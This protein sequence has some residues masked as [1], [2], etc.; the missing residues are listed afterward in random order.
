MDGS[1]EGEQEARVRGREGGRSPWNDLLVSAL[2]S[3]GKLTWKLQ[4]FGGR[5]SHGARGRLYDEVS[6]GRLL[7]FFHF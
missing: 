2:F 6:L 1:Q 4:V 3:A 7:K 5:G